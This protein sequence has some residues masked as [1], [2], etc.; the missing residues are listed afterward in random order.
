MSF[1]LDSIPKRATRKGERLSSGSLSSFMYDMN[2]KEYLLNDEI[3]KYFRS[4]TL[5]ELNCIFYRRVYTVPYLM[6]FV[7]EQY[8][9]MFIK[10]GEFN[11][12]NGIPMSE[13]RKKF[14][15]M[16][17]NDELRERYFRMVVNKIG[18][19]CEK[20]DVNPLVKTAVSYTPRSARND[21]EREIFYLEVPGKR[22]KRP[23]FPANS[24]VVDLTS[25]YA[26]IIENESTKNSGSASNLSFTKK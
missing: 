26:D 16:L 22:V 21:G 24:R 7:D 9:E 19:A 11:E 20:H 4:V 6:L 25:T 2:E 3:E 1:N 8:R 14:Q 13:N 5:G 17:G 12:R 18:K 10:D 23:E 15:A